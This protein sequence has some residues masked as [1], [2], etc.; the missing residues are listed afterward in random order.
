[1]CETLI[2]CD[3]LS[4]ISI[5]VENIKVGEVG[6]ATVRNNVLD[7]TTRVFLPPMVSDHH[8]CSPRSQELRC[9]FPYP[10]RASY[11]QR[12]L[13]R[14]FLAV[15]SSFQTQAAGLFVRGWTNEG[16]QLSSHSRCRH[17]HR[18]QTKTPVESRDVIAQCPAVVRVRSGKIELREDGLQPWTLDAD[19]SSRREN[20]CNLHWRNASDQ[21]RK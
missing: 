16:L 5:R 8:L 7:H 1:M 9:H 4:E 2:T 18:D 15:Y 12:A 21:M 17:L 11:D 14:E 3:Y 10:A 20:H 13:V 6:H 19:Q